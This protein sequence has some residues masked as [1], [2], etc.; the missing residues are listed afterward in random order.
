MNVKGIQLKKGSKVDL[1]GKKTKNYKRLKNDEYSIKIYYDVDKIKDIRHDILNSL[2]TINGFALLMQVD[3]EN[4]K[5][6]EYLLQ[7][8]KIGAKEVTELVSIDNLI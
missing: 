5:Y 6:I 8:I 2:N 3:C 1:I 4:R 7:S